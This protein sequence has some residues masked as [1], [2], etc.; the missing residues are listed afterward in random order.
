MQRR[1]LRRFLSFNGSATL[2]DGKIYYVSRTSGVYVLQAGPEFKLLAHNRFA[3]DS[4]VFNSSPAISEGRIYLRSD[5]A[6]YCMG[7]K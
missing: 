6:L 4:S 1:T 5:Q 3:S 7:S 2:A